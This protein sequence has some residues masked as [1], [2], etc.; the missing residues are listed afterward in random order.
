MSAASRFDL[1][2]VEN[3]NAPFFA[4]IEDSKLLVGLCGGCGEYH[5]YPRPHCPRC[6]SDDVEWVPASGAATLYTWSVIHTNDLPPWAGRVPYT[7]AVVELAEGP[8]MMT[9]I[10]GAEGED[11]SIGMD[12]EI[13][14][15]DLDDELTIA[16]FEPA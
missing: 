10:V 11:L 12:L 7:A 9:H 3:E 15:V 2:L 14:F 6:W 1:P 5:Y 4:A 16:A 13:K 8:R